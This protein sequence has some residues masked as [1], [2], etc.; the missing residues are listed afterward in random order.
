MFHG[1][2]L[3]SSVHHGW[4]E[5]LAN[6]KNLPTLLTREGQKIQ[7]SGDYFRR[8]GGRLRKSDVE[9]YAAE[10]PVQGE[11]DIIKCAA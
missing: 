3:V 1:D 6:R 11:R 2:V 9:T 8:P 10:V 5:S 7:E 4:V